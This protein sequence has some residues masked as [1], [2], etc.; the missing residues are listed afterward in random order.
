M[1]SPAPAPVYPTG[2][3]KGQVLDDP[4]KSDISDLNGQMDMGS[5][6]TESMDPVPITFDPFLEQEKKPGPVF[7][8]E[9]NLLSTVPAQH[10]M[11]QRTRKMNP[12]FTCHRAIISQSSQKSKYPKPDPRVAEL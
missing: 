8:A 10:D 9:K 2:V 1:S 6:Q 11:V 7:L 4:G 5:H 3:S 12:W